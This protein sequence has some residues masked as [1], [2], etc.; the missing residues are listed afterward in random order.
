MCLQTARS[1]ANYVNPYQRRHSAGLSV[2]LLGVNAAN[3]CFDMF[4]NIELFLFEDGQ[5][6]FVF[7]SNN[8]YLLRLEFSHC[9]YL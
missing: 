1:V 8:I 4:I 2:R 5:F 9:T 6:D 3:N 7:Q